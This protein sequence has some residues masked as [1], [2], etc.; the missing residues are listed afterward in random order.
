M[1]Y[2][3]KNDRELQVGDVIDIHQTVN[4]QSLFVVFADK[5]NDLDIKY[6]IDRAVAHDYEYDQEELLE[7][8]RFT[9][10]ASFT[11]ID[12]VEPFLYRN[13]KEERK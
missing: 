4:G 1:I 5:D 13:K 6:Y 11:I 12:N 2:V 9:G 10:E 3:D 7:P 8:C